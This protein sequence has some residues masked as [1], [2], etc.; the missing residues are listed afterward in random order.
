V[1]VV[2]LLTAVLEL[3]TRVDSVRW[4]NYC[5]TGREG[6]VSKAICWR[7]LIFEASCAYSNISPLPSLDH[8]YC[9]AEK[10]V[11]AYFR[12]D[13]VITCINISAI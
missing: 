2:P 11:G 10:G 6:T 12:E 3:K 8:V 9:T 7:G 4:L 13:T 1:I 5:Y